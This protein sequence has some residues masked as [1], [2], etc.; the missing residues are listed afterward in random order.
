MINM[1]YIKQ[2]KIFKYLQGP[3]FYQNFNNS[4]T[5]ETILETRNSYFIHFFHKLSKLF[6]LLINS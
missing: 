6:Y 2:R 1:S 3:Y 5:V 4:L